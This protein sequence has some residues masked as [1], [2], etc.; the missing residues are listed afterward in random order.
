MEKIKLQN[1]E[2]YGYHGAFEE[3]KKLGQKLTVSIE[4]EADLTE[5]CS[6]DQLEDTIDYTKVYEGIKSIVE[7]PNKFSL[8]EHLAEEI[9]HYTI[10]HFELVETVMVNIK[11]PKVPYPGIESFE[12]E[13]FRSRN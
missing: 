12:I 3:E 13:I 10:R 8:L 6:S 2:F 4:L 11:K 7:G 5:A 1:L 9:C